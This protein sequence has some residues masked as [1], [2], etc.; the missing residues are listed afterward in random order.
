MESRADFDEQR[1]NFL[2]MDR[3]R[4]AAAKA[5]RAPAPQRIG[6]GRES[7]RTPTTQPTLRSEVEVPVIDTRKHPPALVI[8]ESG[9]EA[10]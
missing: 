10:A 8:P 3:A 5:S 4:R 2:A 7:S 9:V 6:P 1:S